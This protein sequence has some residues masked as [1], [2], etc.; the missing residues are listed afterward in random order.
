MMG[1]EKEF[2]DSAVTAVA[3]LLASK[4]R[5]WCTYIFA[6]TR[7]LDHVG[8]LS[9]L[10]TRVGK[11]RAQ[12]FYVDPVRLVIRI[13]HQIVDAQRGLALAEDAL[14]AAKT[15]ETHALFETNTAESLDGWYEETFD[16]ASIKA[17]LKDQTLTQWTLQQLVKHHSSVNSDGL[18][19]RV[20]VSNQKNIP[21][22]PGALGNHFVP[23]DLSTQQASAMSSRS[24]AQ[25][26]RLLAK[27]A[28]TASKSIDNLATNDAASDMRLSDRITLTS[29]GSLSAIEQTLRDRGIT[30]MT[31]FPERVSWCSSVVTVYSLFGR[32]HIVLSGT[33]R[34][35]PQI[36][37]AFKISDYEHSGD[38]L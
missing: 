17:Q 1:A 30:S 5:S 8:I 19:W 38:P 10:E 26:K 31:M 29:V 32:L 15:V 36:F 27:L 14:K 6:T 16:L 33:S 21:A 22:N 20:I 34:L 23:V 3:A 9:S 12:A 4:S 24:A 35:D 7:A 2:S 11:D 18:A 37:K 28:G 13:D 25:W